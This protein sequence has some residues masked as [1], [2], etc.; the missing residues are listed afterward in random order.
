MAKKDPDKVEPY[1]IHVSENEALLLSMELTHSMQ[2]YEL[3]AKRQAE[4]GEDAREAKQA[5][6]I[7]ARMSSQLKGIAVM[8]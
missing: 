2:C 1:V 4:R 5:A 3:R 6:L 8:R 7:C